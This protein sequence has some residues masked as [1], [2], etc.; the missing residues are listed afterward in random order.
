MRTEVA[1]GNFRRDLYYQIAVISLRMPSLRERREDIASLAQYFIELFNEKFN[2]Q[3]RPLSESVVS[4]LEGYDWPGNIRELKNLMK[5]YT[6]LDSEEIVAN[7]LKPKGEW[8][9]LVPGMP[10]IKAGQSISLKGVTKDMVRKLERHIITKMLEANG[11]NRA[12]AARALNISYK[13][14]LTKAKFSRCE[15]SSINASAAR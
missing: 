7:E 8:D 14:L 4:M 12:E 6:I 3:A 15:A 10:A 9:D 1:N 13:S 5:R 2:C 11:W